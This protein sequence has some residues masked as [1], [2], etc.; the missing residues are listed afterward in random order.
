MINIVKFPASIHF[1]LDEMAKR[2]IAKLFKKGG[3][4]QCG[5]ITFTRHIKGWLH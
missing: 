4:A 3:A 2:L 1:T 5:H